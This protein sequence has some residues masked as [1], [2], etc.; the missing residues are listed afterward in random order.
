M[1]RKRLY[2]AIQYALLGIPPLHAQAALEGWDA[3]P[4]VFG[5]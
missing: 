2:I 3:S 4:A 1:K 5:G